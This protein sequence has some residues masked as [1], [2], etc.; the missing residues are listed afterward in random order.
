[1]TYTEQLNTTAKISYADKC[2]RMTEEIETRTSL[3]SF[4]ILDASKAGKN[5]GNFK[6]VT[7]Y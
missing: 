5:S 3:L 2:T 6:L 1:M 7:L 4:V